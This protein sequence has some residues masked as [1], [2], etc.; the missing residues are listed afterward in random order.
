MSH[1]GFKQDLFFFKKPRF[2]AGTEVL[3]SRPSSPRLEEC[4]YSA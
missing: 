3:P 4:V 2:I 1:N